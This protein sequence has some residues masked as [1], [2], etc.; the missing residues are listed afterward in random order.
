LTLTEIAPG[1]DLTHDILEQM[2]FKPIVS[3]NL[4][5]MDEAVFSNV[6]LSLEERF[7]K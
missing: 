5:M 7:A 1:I 6:G 3:S 2:A 4:K